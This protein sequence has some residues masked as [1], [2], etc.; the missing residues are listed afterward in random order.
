MRFLDV[1]TDFAFK[2]VFGSQQSKPVL[3]DFLNAMLDYTGEFAIAD[4]EIVD[5]YQIPMIQG[6]KDTYVDVKA[7]LTNGSHVIIEMQVLHVEGFEQRILYNAAKQYS[8]Q[9]LKGEHCDD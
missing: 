6:M 9:L 8:S 4:L 5:P 3:I 7:V 2:K 1:R